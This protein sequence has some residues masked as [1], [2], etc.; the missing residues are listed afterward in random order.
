ML[1]LAAAGVG[2]AS[3][4]GVRSLS[5]SSSGGGGGVSRLIRHAWTYPRQRA[6]ALGSALANPSS[7]WSSESALGTRR[8]EGHAAAGAVPRVD[9][10]ENGGSKPTPSATPST[11]E[12]EQEQADLI[13]QRTVGSSSKTSFATSPSIAG[14]NQVPARPETSPNDSSV[15]SLVNNFQRRSKRTMNHSSEKHKH[16]L[17]ASCDRP[18]FLFSPR[19]DDARDG[20]IGLIFNK[21]AS[22]RKVPL[23]RPIDHG[24]GLSTDGKTAKKNNRLEGVLKSE[25]ASSQEA[26]VVSTDG[27]YVGNHLESSFTDCT[28][29]EYPVRLASTIRQYAGRRKRI[30]AHPNGSNK[31]QEPGPLGAT[32]NDH[33]LLLLIDH[34]HAHPHL[35]STRAWD[36]LLAFAYRLS[37]LSAVRSILKRMEEQRLAWS[38]DTGKIV[39]RG[40]ILRSGLLPSPERRRQ[41]LERVARTRRSPSQTRWLEHY[42]KRQTMIA[43]GGEGGGNEVVRASSAFAARI[44][45]R[46]I[47]FGT[48]D[49]SWQSIVLAG[50]PWAPLRVGKQT[51]EDMKS[52]PSEQLSN[53]NVSSNGARS[54]L[55]AA[56]TGKT[57]TAPLQRPP[58]PRDIA[59]IMR[60]FEGDGKTTEG[61]A[62]TP[63]VFV[64]LLR[65]VLAMSPS[66]EHIPTLRDSIGAILGL[67]HTQGQGSVLDVL[68]LYLHPSLG[69]SP[70]QVLKEYTASISNSTSSST[71]LPMG[72]T[73]TLAL[74][75]LKRQK[76]G[77]ATK[78]REIINWYREQGLERYITRDHWT[79]VL[80]LVRRDGRGDRELTSWVLRNAQE[81]DSEMHPASK[82]LP[83]PTRTKCH[84]L[85]DVKFARHGKQAIAYAE[86]KRKLDG[87]G[88]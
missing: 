54:T 43:A 88:V 36:V 49:P 10:S 56:S 47:G 11:S 3:G 46:A 59:T 71:A 61:V 21:K 78:A 26:P 40:Q 9:V 67:K 64:A 2:G 37:N 31:L 74:R 8:V 30:A 75:C 70:L 7:K 32:S 23:Y 4:S 39:Y 65:Y 53:Q 15:K 72:Q 1:G 85:F 50:G 57:G 42:R 69:F 35:T 41:R 83:Q 17:Y 18:S 51:V 19:S 45:R 55:D 28:R 80:V 60:T 86:A 33:L 87:E 68:H 81:S 82:G 77:A 84:E 24:L 73:L 20:A 25:I 22:A 62:M 48:A 66:T 79:Q 12:V 63:E 76:R 58:S 34:G 5:S 38:S 13:D 14:V 44:A 16:T 52:K 6:T 27:R 29:E